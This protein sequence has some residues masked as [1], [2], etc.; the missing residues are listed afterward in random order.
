MEKCIICVDGGGT[1]TEV[2]AFT[3]SGKEITSHI[4]GSGNF[5]F[6]AEKAVENVF[7]SVD[8]VYQAIIDEYECAMIQMGISG[9]G[10]YAAKEQLIERFETTFK[11]KTN[12]V[13]DARLAL[14]SILQDKHDDGVL[15]LA[16]TGSACYGI[17]GD[18]T[19][20]IGGWGH[21]LG[22]EGSANHLMLQTFKMMITDEDTGKAP[23]ELS[24]K[25]LDH[26]K[27]SNTFDLKKYVYHQPKAV[28]ASNAQFI[29]QCAEEGDQDAI[30]LLKRSGE[31]LADQVRLAFERLQLPTHAIIG[32]QG[33]F[34]LNSQIVNQSLKDSIRSFNPEAQFHEDP[35]R[36]VRG[37]YY[38]ALRELKRG[39]K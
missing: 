6:E 33:S 10:A 14:F 30:E 18:R 38:L 4:G 32:C 5:A 23:R 35:E 3:L 7:T 12:I 2:V 31:Q 9:Y 13:D 21:L 39:E 16:G 27:L 1:K 34:V 29:N 20:L 11:T 25:V 8:T 24:K 37:A 36:P 19:L 22:D 28:V 17:K 15:I 26:L